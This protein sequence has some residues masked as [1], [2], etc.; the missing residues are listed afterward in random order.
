[1]GIGACASSAG[2]SAAAAV[3][4]GYTIGRGGLDGGL[5][6]VCTRKTGAGGKVVVGFGYAT[7]VQGMDAGDCLGLSGVGE[8]TVVVAGSVVIVGGGGKR[9]R[10]CETYRRW[11]Y[12]RGGECRGR[13]CRMLCEWQ[14]R[15]FKVG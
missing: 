7:A 3:G 5:D 10:L 15:A 6:V 11:G 4:V 9:R 13:G 1:M 8:D 2:V 12:W 14:R